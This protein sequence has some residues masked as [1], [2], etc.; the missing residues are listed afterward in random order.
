MAN[1]TWFNYEAYM[2]N[3]LAQMQATDSNYSLD[4]LF[5]DFANAG[6]AGAEGAYNHFV[7]YGADEEVA[8]NALF[9]AKEYY[10]A[11]AVEYYTKQGVEVTAATITD[12]QIN[13]VKQLI[14]QAGMNAWTHY[15]QYGSSEGVNPSN[16][17]DAAAYCAAKAAVMGG[18]WTAK[19]IQDAITAAHMTVLE[20]FLQYAGTGDMEVK[21]DATF[22][23]ADDQ[24]VP[25]AV[26]S[27][28]VTLTVNPDTVNGTSGD[29]VIN[30][31]LAG[32]N[33][34][35]ATLTP[36]DNIDG[37]AGTD[38]LNLYGT[39]NTNFTG[40]TMKNVEIVNNYANAGINVSAFA[41][42]KEVWNQTSTASK[43]TTAQLATKVGFV[44]D[45]YDAA[46]NFKNADGSADA[47]TIAVKDAKI[48]D[49]TADTDTTALTVANIENLT[50]EAAGKNDLG[51][52]AI[53]AAKTLVITG[54]GSVKATVEAQTALT[55]ID[56]SNAGAVKLD[57]SAVATDLTFTGSKGDDTLNVGAN[58]TKADK[59][60]GG[61]GKDTL[62]ITTASAGTVA[63]AT[64]KDMKGVITGF[65]TLK[66]TNA[67]AHDIDAAKYGDI[68]T[69]V[70][71][72]GLGAAKS[73]T[74]VTSG[75]DVTLGDAV[76]S[77]GTLTVN[78][79]DASKAGHDDTLNL[80]FNDATTTAAGAS[81]MGTILGAGIENVN[82]T[83]KATDADGNPVT[84][85]TGYTASLSGL[86]AMQVLTITGDK[87]LD[88]T[89]G[90]IAATITKIDAANLVLAKDTDAGLKVTTDALTHGVAI[91]GTNGVDVIT[92]KGTD[93]TKVASS[94]INA[95]AG[96]D[97][98]TTAATSFLSELTGG[99]GK[100]T[101][102]VSLTK[103][104]TV[105]TPD[106][107]SNHLVT[108]MDF[109]KGTDGDTV[110]VDTAATGDFVKYTYAK[111]DTVEAVLAALCK[112]A[113]TG[114]NQINT[115]FTDG[116]DTYLVVNKGTQD[117][118]TD[119]VIVKLAGVHDLTAVT[120]GTGANA[121]F[122]TAE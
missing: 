99:E 34:D 115:Y 112:V 5:T 94:I 73:I 14:D 96:N 44:G 48:V 91:T 29:D 72:G 21:A 70:L 39:A 66:V 32:I 13:N 9:S 20:H 47:A 63:S 33:G 71:A 90:D 118:V 75:V 43:V 24:K 41:D 61:E 45:Q 87:A 76:T 60:A 85:T 15:Q 19:G 92:L 31:V 52:V 77:G 25:S 38:T 18:D 11:K 2:N 101:F 93:T 4:Q 16:A 103:V 104:G 114:S 106:T 80:T 108:I 116:T 22:P 42:V 30:A 69:F 58:L 54:E 111:S 36:G 122:V 82:L 3:K 57:V 98:I 6:F 107:Y 1:P 102:D 56:A 68:N 12:F 17:F 62:V 67:L 53:A 88:L 40:V 46:V 105:T 100:D 121:G 74:H 55:T 81:A 50:I 64:D 95:G 89:S 51:N 120:A 28:P 10:A 26:V 23:V 8:P 49:T 86:T 97:K 65:E 79:T 113:N 117:T 27:K 37:G 7:Q 119:D 84:T 110:K 59:L 109:A 83:V 78:I 35:S